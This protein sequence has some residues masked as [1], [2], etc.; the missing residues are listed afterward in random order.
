MYTRNWI[1]S[2]DV[3]RAQG[4]LLMSGGA[5]QRITACFF[6]SPEICC[7]L[8]LSIEFKSPRRKFS[9][10]VREDGSDV[11]KKFERIR[12]IRRNLRLFVEDGLNRGGRLITKILNNSRKAK[13]INK[14]VDFNYG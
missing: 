5:W 6:S 11:G 7:T 3:I 9:R 1:C 8:S 4:E 10:P 2:L 12:N 13:K 14:I